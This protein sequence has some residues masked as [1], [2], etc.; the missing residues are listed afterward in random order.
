MGNAGLSST[1][2]ERLNIFPTYLGLE[3][4]APLTTDPLL[5]AKHTDYLTQPL[6]DQKLSPGNKDPKNTVV[7]IVMLNLWKMT[8]GKIQ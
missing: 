6:I 1:D 2:V 4:E 7:C 5:R 8:A 3:G